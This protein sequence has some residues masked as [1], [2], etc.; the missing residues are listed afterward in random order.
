[1]AR[2]PAPVAGVDPGSDLSRETARVATTE[3]DAVSENADQVFPEGEATEQ[4]AASSFWKCATCG[5]V[6]GSTTA[7]CRMCFAARP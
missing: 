1:M 4:L 7:S 3:R 5:A 2:D 6:N